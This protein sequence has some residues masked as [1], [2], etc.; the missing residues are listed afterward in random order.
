MKVTRPVDAKVNSMLI[1]SVLRDFELSVNIVDM[2]VR[3]PNLTFGVFCYIRSVSRLESSIAL[4]RLSAD[5]FMLLY[6]SIFL[7]FFW[8]EVL[9]K[10][11]LSCNTP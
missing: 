10:Y 9:H 8:Y 3:V 4:S 2:G 5:F 1:F 11:R 6:S 7:V